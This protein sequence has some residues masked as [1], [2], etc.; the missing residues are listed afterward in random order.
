METTKVLFY[1]AKPYDQEI[2]D[3]ANQKHHFEIKYLTSHLNQDTANLADG[4]PVVCAFVNDMIDTGVIK[5]LQQAGVKLIALRSAGFNNV[6]L[7]AAYKKIKVVRVPGYSPYAVA[8]H[9]VALMLTLNRK[10]HRA[11]NR[12]RENNFSLNGLLGFDM[13]GKTAGIIGTG[14]IGRTLAAILH[15]FGLKLL[16]Y[17]KVK[18][19]DFAKEL[20]AQYVA[21][22]ELYRQADI[23]SLNCPLTP[24]TKYMINRDSL[25]AM[26]D[27]V[28]LIN[29]GRGK[30][31][32][33]EDL[34]HALKEKKVGA[35]GLDVYEEE[36][37]YFFEDFSDKIIDD[38]LL[39][40]LLTFPN[41]VVTSHQGFFTREA[42]SNIAQT[43]LENIR[44]F[45]TGEAMPNEICHRCENN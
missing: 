36:S 41:V 43:T 5:R 9:S 40:R 14:K 6:D 29:T 1:D 27:H 3:Q 39:A 2:F 38:D 22:Q 35:A 31:I 19:E 8:E 34:I 23:I 26:K 33:T 12:T 21:L 16:L 45:V 42:V 4:W 24:E 30:L 7:K 17:D 13:H 11:Y 18:Q 20:D 44:Q 32:K 37:D 15:G 10:I 25:A 28:M